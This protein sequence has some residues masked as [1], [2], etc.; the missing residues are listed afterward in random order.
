MPG[1]GRVCCV[2]CIAGQRNGMMRVTDT[3]PFLLHFRPLM[4]GMVHG[5]C[6]RSKRETQKGQD[7]EKTVHDKKIRPGGVLALT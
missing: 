4:M 2:D 6:C 3:G 7:A 5:P 1:H